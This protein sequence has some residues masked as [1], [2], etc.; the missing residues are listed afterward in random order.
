MPKNIEVEIRGQLTKEKLEELKEKFSR[1]GKKLTE[2]DRVII[3]YSN[4]LP[5]SI[6]NQTTDIRLRATNGVPEII[7]KLGQWGG[8]DQREEISAFA[9]PGQFDS[10]VQIFKVLDLTKG[11]LC[12]RKIDVFEYQGVE[13]AL[14]GVPNGHSYYFEAEKMVDENDDKDQATQEILNVCQNLGLQAFSQQEFFDYI[15]KLNKEINELF[16]ADTCPKDYFKTR[17]GI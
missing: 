8:S 1:E 11:M 7:I 10:L 9:Q 3:A 15:H 5:G 4:F 6:E 17:F 12:Q 14:V 2:K 16:D 13:F